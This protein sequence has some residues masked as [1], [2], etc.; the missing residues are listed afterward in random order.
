MEGALYGGL[1]LSGASVA[2][3]S[4]TPEPTAAPEAPTTAPE[5][6]PEEEMPEEEM[7]E[8]EEEMPEEEEA[9][10]PDEEEGRIFTPTF[11]SWIPDLHP[12]VPDYWGDRANFQ[13]APVEG[14]GIERFVAEARD[15]M[16]T[17]DI[18]GGMTPFV[19]MKSLIKA[20]VIEPWDPYIPKE[21]LDDLIP[22]IREECSVDGKL[23]CWPFLLDIISQAWNSGMAVEAGLDGE[24]APADWDEWMESGKQVMDSG[25]GEFGVTFDAHGWRSIAPVTHSIDSDVYEGPEGRFDFTN[26]AAVE[27]LKLL[28]QFYE[29][30]HPD[31]LL[32]GASDGGV[33]GTPDEVA[34]AVQ[35]VAYY[36]KYQNAP[37][38]M[39]ALWPDPDLLRISRL[40]TA[41]GGEGSSVFWDTGIALFTYGQ[42]KQEAAEYLVD[43]TYDMDIWKDSLAGS[44]STWPTQVPPY[45]S[46]WDTLKNDPPE[47]MSGLEW[48]FSLRDSLDTAVAIKNHEF[49]LSQF[50]IGKP[51]WE[52]YIL[53]EEPDPKVALQETYDAVTAEIEK[54]GGES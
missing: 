44:E 24:Y 17:W 18:Y 21:V 53:G 25:A 20:G 45:A 38:R 47:W 27:A 39:A 11:Y 37:T 6:A 23:Y 43:L 30:S 28:K 33:N 32:E 41:A 50:Q 3:S 10:P 19:E 14:F 22:S 15:K 31:V 46:V 4:C 52:K 9:P 42:N 5:A 40:P 8:E 49:G 2:L 54:V 36:F 7:P 48:L 13:I 26:D 35:R 34:F 16:S 1:A 12:R 51:Y 29:L